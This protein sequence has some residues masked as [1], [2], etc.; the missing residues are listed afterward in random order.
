MRDFLREFPGGQSSEK[1]ID[2]KNSQ[3]QNQ[4]C[5]TQDV[6]IY[7][8]F[9]LLVFPSSDAPINEIR[10][11]E[12]ATPQNHNFCLRNSSERVKIIVGDGNNSK[13][14]N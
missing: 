3:T 5:F 4:R 1:P 13:L 14:I 11:G 7:L 2:E 6:M 10:E 8:V 9:N 12:I